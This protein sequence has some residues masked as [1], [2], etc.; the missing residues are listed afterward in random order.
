MGFL[1]RPLDLTAN[2]IGNTGGGGYQKKAISK[3]KN[4]GNSIGQVIF[5]QLIARKK[6]EKIHMYFSEL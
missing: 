6:K 3:I 5:L 4:M 1:S 2:I